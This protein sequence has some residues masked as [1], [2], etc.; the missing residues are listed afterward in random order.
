MIEKIVILHSLKILLLLSSIAYTA[1][2]TDD[3]LVIA[4]AGGKEHEQITDNVL[5]IIEEANLTLN[6]AKCLFKRKKI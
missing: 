1:F 3:D 5:A 4:T 6:P 2:A